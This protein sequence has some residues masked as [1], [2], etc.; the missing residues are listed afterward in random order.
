VLDSVLDPTVS[1]T[2]DLLKI[3]CVTVVWLWLP[4]SC[5]FAGT[6]S[7]G[8]DG[9]S[10]W[11]SLIRVQGILKAYQRA[12]GIHQAALTVKRWFSSCV[13]EAGMHR[14]WRARSRESN[15]GT[16][17]RVGEKKAAGSDTRMGFVSSQAWLDSRWERQ[18]GI[19]FRQK[20]QPGDGSPRVLRRASKCTDPIAQWQSFRLPSSMS[21]WKTGRLIPS[22]PGSQ[23]GIVLEGA[24]TTRRPSPMSSGAKMPTPCP[25]QQ[26]GTAKMF[27]AQFFC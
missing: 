13:R 17:C 9:E 25:A 19:A 14:A 16:S 15:T 3:H 26:Q 4:P 21:G 24:M 8:S 20:A 2:G 6:S 27:T 7:L 1:L 23:G 11:P 18:A 10:V 5:W 12:T 22:Q